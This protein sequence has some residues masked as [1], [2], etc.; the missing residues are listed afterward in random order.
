MNWLPMNSYTWMKRKLH[1]ALAFSWSDGW[2][3]F[4]AWTLLLAVDLSLR[5]LPFQPIQEFVARARRNT[6]NL[7]AGEAAAMIR[8]LQ[9]LV[10]VAGRHHLYPMRCLQRAL[11]LQWLLGWR[12]IPT[13]LR[14]GVQKEADGLR[15]HAWLEHASRPIGEPQSIAARFV[16]LAGQ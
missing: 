14:I 3:L 2:I 12:G 4:Q 7:R 16:P 15:A 5:V 6:A 11:V 9:R 10:G 13:E 8:R 1:T